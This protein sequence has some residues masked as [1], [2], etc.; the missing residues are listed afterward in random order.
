MS[1]LA[2]F[3]TACASA[4]IE[5]F[6][7]HAG[8]LLLQHFGPPNQPAMHTVFPAVAAE[9]SLISGHLKVHFVEAPF[10]HFT[11]KVVPAL[12]TFGLVFDPGSF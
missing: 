4:E 8:S 11:V 1:S 9:T 3:F 12:S 6:F 5:Q 7:L 10:L 2:S